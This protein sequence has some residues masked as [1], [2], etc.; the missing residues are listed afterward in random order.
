MVPYRTGLT[1]IRLLLR[2]ICDLL[3]TYDQVIKSVL[4]AP[5]H[6]YVDALKQ[7]CEDFLENTTN[8]RP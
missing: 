5:Q 7:A 8:P 1:T 3:T 6:V 2:K 4:P